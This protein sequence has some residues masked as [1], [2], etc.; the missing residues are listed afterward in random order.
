MKNCTLKAFNLSALNGKK[1]IGSFSGGSVTSD[2]GLVLLREVD[3][4]FGIT[5]KLSSLIVD[6]RNQAYVDHS[7]SEMLKQRIYALAAGYEDLNDH[8]YLRKDPAFQVIVN[9]E[10]ELS[11]SSTLSRLENTATREDCVRMNIGLVE[12][13]I[14]QHAVAPAEL[15]LD[16]DPTDYRLY[17]HQE[18]RHYHGYY[19]DYCYLPLYVFCGEHLLVSYLRPS[20]IDPALHAGAILKLLV[21][22]LRSVWPKVRITFRADSAFAR[23]HI[24]HWCEQ[25]NVEYIVGMAQ[26][27]R[28]LKLVAPVLEKAKNKYT[29][30]QV[31]QR[32]FTSF[33][34]AAKS[35]KSSRTIIAKVE[36]TSNGSNIRMLVTNLKHNDPQLVYDEHY[37]PRGDM[38]NQIKQQKLDLF[39]QRVSCHKFMAN[40]FRMLLSAYAH[41]LLATLRQVALRGTNYANSYY[42]T[43]RNRLLKIGAVVIKNTRRVQFLFS[44]HYPEQEL[45]HTILEKLV[46]T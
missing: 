8:I 27:S 45:F 33:S 32:E 17:G 20:D 40:Q 5:K 1:V 28:N 26:N 3:K 2:G 13:F 18:D 29:A 4:K 38:E 21:K 24:L 31:K 12:H 11:S 35:W 6:K 14:N 23:R 30:T 15:V 44:A 43:L 9:Q 7:Y 34:Y 16:F 42:S 36:Y 19:G 39:A 10:Q 41:V 25:H 22:K 37:C 46:P